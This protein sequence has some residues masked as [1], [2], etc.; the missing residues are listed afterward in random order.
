MWCT[1]HSQQAC[2]LIDIQRIISFISGTWPIHKTQ[3]THQTHMNH[4]DKKYGCNVNATLAAFITER[5]R[6][7]YVVRSC[8]F[9][10]CPQGAQQQTHRTPLLLSIDGTDSY[11]RTLDRPLHRPCS[12]WCIGGYTRVYAVYQPPGFFL[13]AYTHLSDHK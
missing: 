3:Y 7:L 5:Q 12:Q 1:P 13:T 8:R 6:L 11:R 10:Y 9:I 2:R 4:T